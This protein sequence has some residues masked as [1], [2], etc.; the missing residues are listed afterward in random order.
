MQKHVKF[1]APAVLAVAIGGY[2]G[3]SAYASGKAEK[4]LE[5]WVYDNGLSDQ[6]SWRSVSSTPLGGTVTIDGLAI[7]SENPLVGK[8]DID[9]ERLAISDYED[10]KERKRVTLD[11]SGIQM[12]TG[13]KTAADAL[14]P[15]LHASGRS[16]LQ[17]FDLYLK[18]D[19]K[20]Q[21]RE[22]SLG[23]E[24]RATLPDLLATEASFELGSLPDP[25]EL[26]N[27]AAMAGN[28][29]GRGMRGALGALESIEIGKT[30][31]SVRDLGYFARRGLIEQR[32]K[33]PVD[34]LKGDPD[35]QRKSAHEADVAE[36]LRGCE[37]EL[38]SVLPDA[39]EACAAWVGLANGTENGAK[40]SIAPEKPLRVAEFIRLLG[41]PQQAG[42]MFKRIQLKVDTL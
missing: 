34:P 42:P 16:E 30:S 36:Q 25:A 24:Y 23:L 37:Q 40:I 14:K 11:I 19:Y 9:V 20:E 18:A 38:A 21:E 6:V 3:L 41:A 5:D 29:F 4:Q 12:P 8:L 39:E 28:P 26:A 1:I 2:F 22:R 27:A 10:G 17:P 32:Y 33:Y 35:K 13:Q 31:A 7:R 15:L